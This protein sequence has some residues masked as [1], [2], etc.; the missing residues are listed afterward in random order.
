MKMISLLLVSVTVTVVC[1]PTARAKEPTEWELFNKD[2]LVARCIVPFDA[3]KRGPQAR[4]EML[5]RLGIKR[6]AY[7]WRP[8]DVPT[9]EEEILQ[10]KKQYRLK[11]GLQQ[12]AALWSPFAQRKWHRNAALSE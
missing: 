6:V 10:Y 12:L 4:A 9:F 1:V 11:P 7:D 5:Q 3:K 2:N 8:P